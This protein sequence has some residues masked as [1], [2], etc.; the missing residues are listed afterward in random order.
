MAGKPPGSE[1]GLYYDSP[2]HQLDAGDYLRTPSGRMYEVLDVRVQER[3]AHVGRQH[4]RCLVITVDQV[5]DVE[6]VFPIHW[7]SRAPGRS[8]ARR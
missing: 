8:R 6:R 1:V 5:T 2:I 3:G 7:Y 4:L